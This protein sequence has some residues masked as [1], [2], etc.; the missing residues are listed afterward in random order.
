MAITHAA[1]RFVDGEWW[2][3]YAGH[4]RTRA[5]RKNCEHCG[6]EFFAHPGNWKKSR[7]CSKQCSRRRWNGGR[8]KRNGY[9]LI[10]APDHPSIKGRTQKYRLEHR[11]VM[12]QMLGR[13]LEQHERVHHKNGKRDDNRPENL[14]LWTNGHSMPGK[15][16]SDI[17]HCATCTCGN[18]S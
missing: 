18:D 15:R 7:F 9:V 11:L 2:Y 17:P 6:E 5:K 13:Y 10:Y 8:I 3:Y 14:E 12:E 4:R 1:L 16:V